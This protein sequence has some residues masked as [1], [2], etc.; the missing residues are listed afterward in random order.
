MGLPV[1]I[2]EIAP[3][4]NPLTTPAA[5]DWKAITSYVRHGHIRRGRNH[6]LARTSPGEGTYRLRNVGR[7]FDPS[8]TSSPYSP[9]LVP[10]VR[11]RHRVTVGASTYHLFHGF[12]EDWG[13]S[14]SPRPLRNAGD[15]ECVVKA[16]DAFKLFGLIDLTPAS[17][18]V[19]K[20][21]PVAYWRLRETSGTTAVDDSD[22]GAPGPFNGTYT[23]GV[24]LGQTGPFGGSV[25]ADFD[26]VDDYVNVAGPP[27]TLDFADDMTLMCWFRR[28]T[29]GGGMTL[30]S[31]DGRYKLSLI[32]GPGPVKFDMLGFGEP[33]VESVTVPAAGTW[34]HAA[35][36]RRGGVLEIY[37]DGVLEGTVG[38]ASATGAYAGFRLGSI[39]GGGFFLDG[40]MAHA[41]AFNKALAPERI[42]TIAGAKIDTMAAMLSGAHI[43]AI[44]DAIGWPAGERSIDVG[45]SMIQ[46]VSPSGSALEWMLKIA[47]ET[48]DGLFFVR[49]DGVVAFE[50]RQARYKAPFNTSTGTWGD[51]AAELGY[52]DLGV[53]ND[54]Q[55]IYTQA[56][57]NRLG[58]D[59]VVVE[60]VTARQRFGPRPIERTDL[61]L[62]SDAE[63]TDAANHLLG[64]YKD[65]HPR[66][67]RLE[68]LGAADNTRLDHMAAR[69]VLDRITVRRRAP[70]ANLLPLKNQS[71]VEV[72]LTGIYTN[73][74]AVVTLTRDTVSP[75]DGLASLKVVT[76]GAGSAQGARL[77]PGS[78]AGTAHKTP[79]VAGRAYG[80]SAYIRGNVGGEPLRLIPYWYTA[81][82]VF[83]GTGPSLVIDLTTSFVRY[84]LRAAVAPDTA[85]FLAF[86]EETRTA[87]AATWWTDDHQVEEGGP[88]E[89]VPAGAPVFDE[90][91]HIEG[92]THDVTP[93][94][95]W[96]TTWDL[97][98]ADP[99]GYWI[100]GDA[101]YGLL[102][103]TTR[104]G[105]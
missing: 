80:L 94:A 36:V 37:V 57:V 29:T 15:A 75:F 103:Q 100:L 67:E 55:D 4:V 26:G 32:G 51:D 64:R 76:D 46:E 79:V 42:R 87:V 28:D 54:D 50:E 95:S 18:E 72:D 91:A 85:A 101:V 83:I 8:N 1:D 38:G 88:T 102:G 99:I 11:L 17:T 62:T 59:P 92:I 6:E 7:R 61:L 78:G 53:R 27:A 58:G 34:Y 5:G 60:D 82:D 25:A 69:G 84:E 23:G 81:A 19:L 14:W 86:V 21:G 68:I 12:V 63:V 44:L 35:A 89:W 48:E 97:V 96:T 16:V 70:S 105:W 2:V 98:P 66:V 43:T 65:F 74:P 52:S 40:R 73:G 49:P 77:G 90:D 39:V 93:G 56:K 47:E 45:S 31:A 20:D 3:G 104:L 30:F 22:F 13:Q 9:N 10:M 71:D 24:L 41:A 33:N